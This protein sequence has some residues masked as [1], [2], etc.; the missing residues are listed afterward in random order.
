MPLQF[1]HLHYA[2]PAAAGTSGLTNS[3]MILPILLEAQCQ[4]WTQWCNYAT[5]LA[6][7]TTMMMLTHSG[8][9]NSVTHIISW[10][11]GV[12]LDLSSY[13]MIKSRKLTNNWWLIKQ[14]AS[15]YGT[16]PVSG[17]QLSGEARLSRM[18]PKQQSGSAVGRA[19][20]DYSVHARS[21]PAHTA[22]QWDMQL[23]VAG[24]RRCMQVCGE[25]RPGDG[26]S[27]SSH[28]LPSQPTLGMSMHK[29]WL[30]KCFTT[31]ITV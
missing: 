13:P 12:K 25:V 28:R 23:N 10:S 9:A 19:L 21:V 2:H 4:P 5:A 17:Q 14:S 30:R 29:L 31:H 16:S 15:H 7:Y 8:Y 20:R 22:A 1:L 11:R 24:S 3:E 27:T 6:G 18:K 26:D